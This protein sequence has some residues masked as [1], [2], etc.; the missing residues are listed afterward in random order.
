M[1]IVRD[2]LRDQVK[3]AIIDQILAGKL[4]S[5]GRINESVLSVELGVSRTPLREALLH[6]EQE[7]YVQATPGRGF[8]VLPMSDADVR[9]LYPLVS[10]LEAAAM[11]VSDP[12]P[13]L[14]RAEQLNDAIRLHEDD[15][16]KALEYDGEFHAVLVQ[17]CTNRR[18]LDVLESQKRIMSRYEATY[19]R[20][21]AGNPVA[22]RTVASSVDEHAEIIAA[23]RR[24][25][26][27]EAV[28][29]LDR[30]WVRGMER[31]LV[32]LGERDAS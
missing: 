26:M 4:P 16:E 32:I 9:E 30:N 5:P 22:P 17:H 10:L 28:A 21:T 8:A 14:D 11:R 24:G 6:L 27:D 12:A 18:I 20:R 29:A 31:L 15:A 2:L 3:R 1:T 23:L 7:G 25:A 13:D 19:M